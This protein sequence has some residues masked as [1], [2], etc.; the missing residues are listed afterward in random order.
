MHFRAAR[1][2][3]ADRLTGIVMAAKARWGYSP[4]QLEAWRPELAISS[5]LLQEQLVY[6]LEDGAS[7]LG[8]YSLRMDANRCELDNF[9]IAPGA[10]GHGHGRALLA[11]ACERAREMG[12]VEMHID[13]DPNAAPFYLKCGAV[14]TDHVAAA[15]SGDPDRRRPQM[16]LRL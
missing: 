12:A 10:M 4:A 3:E 5:A 11:H 13:A 7:I 15:I 6:V 9:W 16:R 1:S 14:T 2:D 8:L